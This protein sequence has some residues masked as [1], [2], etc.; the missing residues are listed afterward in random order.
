M[1]TELRQPDVGSISESEKSQERPNRVV[2][3]REGQRSRLWTWRPF[4]PG[5]YPH[6]VQGHNV[7]TI[8]SFSPLLYNVY[9]LWHYMI[10]QIKLGSVALEPE[11]PDYQPP[12]VTSYL[13][14]SMELYTAVSSTCKMQPVILPLQGYCET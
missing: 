4:L 12:L 13:I 11:R 1:L 14:S 7:N 10:H 9:S 5:L 2:S 6:R 8:T 3:G